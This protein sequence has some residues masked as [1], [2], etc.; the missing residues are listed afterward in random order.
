MLAALL[1]LLRRGVRPAALLHSPWLGV[2]LL[3]LLALAWTLSFAMVAGLVA[4]QG[5]MLFPALPAI[6]IMLAAGLATF[7]SAL[8]RLLLP[9]LALLALALPFTVIVP[10]YEWRTLPPD[11]AQATISQPVYARYAKPW[12]Q[13]IVLRGWHAPPPPAAAGTTVDIRLLWHALERVEHN[14]TVFVHLVDAEGAIVAEHNSIPQRG[15][16]PMPHWTPGDWLTDTHPL[17]LPPDLPPGAYTLRVGLY[18]PWQSDPRQGRRQE[19]WDATGEL[20]G[21]MAEIGTLRVR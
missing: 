3:A 9:L 6:A 18:L 2:A 17:A 16:F 11:R 4:W 5:R 7:G 13:G 21:D 15:Q 19:V 20:L 8:P 10:A 1:G 14:W 12:E